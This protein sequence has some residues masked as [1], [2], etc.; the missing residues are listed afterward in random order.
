MVDGT[1]NPWFY[2]DVGIKGDRIATIS[3]AGAL[4]T[5]PA[6]LRIDARGR[7]VAPGFIDIQ[8]Q[9]YDAHIYGDGRVISKISQGVTTE[10]LGEGGTPAPANNA[11]L[12][13]LL[14]ADSLMKRAML[15]FTGARGFGAWLRAMERHGSR[16]NVGSYLGAEVP[17]IFAKGY[18]E[19]PATPAQLDTMRR[20]MRDAM[21]DGAFGLGSALIYPPGTYA[22]TA[23]LAAMTE[24]LAPYHGSYITH[25][26]SEDDQLFEAIDEA[27]AIGRQGGVPVDIYHLKAAARRNWGKAAEMVAKID[28][29]RRAGQGRRHWWTLSSRKTGALARSPSA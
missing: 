5:T 14:P 6:A 13:A 21:R 4:A 8:A 2:G 27:L 15:G 24:A 18:A 12:A 26:R 16:V 20:V 23:E 29:A 11:M 28:S 22:S 3:A 10:I 17:R 7:V 9:S 1:G 19:G 25:I